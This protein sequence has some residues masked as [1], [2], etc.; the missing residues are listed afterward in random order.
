MK[1]ATSSARST[2]SLFQLGDQGVGIHTN[3]KRRGS[4][5]FDLI[6]DL[7]GHA[8]ALR[9]QLL[10]LQAQSRAVIGPVLDPSLAS[11]TVACSRFVP[12]CSKRA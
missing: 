8:V 6:Y 4:Y 11:S 1:S 12:A 9:L 2:T 7:V 3:G 5:D 10:Q